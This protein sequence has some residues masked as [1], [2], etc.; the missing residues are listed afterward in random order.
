MDDPYGSVL[1]YCQP[2]SNWGSC[3]NIEKVKVKWEGTGHPTPHA[4]SL[5]EVPSLIGT[6]PTN[7]ILRGPTFTYFKYIS[8]PSQH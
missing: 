6:F 5:A 7:K 1:I 2:S 8:N 3:G 4:N